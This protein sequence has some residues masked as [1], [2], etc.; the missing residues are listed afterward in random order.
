M[1][2]KTNQP[3]K[4]GREASGRTAF[5]L[6]ELLVVILVLAI[7]A[8]LLLP[9]ISRAR[10]QS[11][12][13]RCAS[14]LRQI[15]TAFN[16]Y[17]QDSDEVVF[18][19]STNVNLYGMDWYVY[20]G[21]ETGNTDLGQAGLFNR[22]V[23]RPLNPYVRHQIE[24]FHCPADTRALPEWEGHT[25]FD[26]V[27]NSYLYNAVGAP[28]DPNQGVGGFNAIRFSSANAPSRTVLFLDTSLVKTAAAWHPGGKGN[29]CFADGHVEFRDLPASADGAS[30]TWIP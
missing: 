22:I 13:P 29:V 27:G 8:G 6:V 11:K 14:N 15:Y 24:V 26:W 9:A 3:L 12:V 16:L 4:P 21:R 25:H 18:W 17:L 23:P 28:F 2:V 10:D 7:L 30:T 5:T 1:F 20:G 19:N